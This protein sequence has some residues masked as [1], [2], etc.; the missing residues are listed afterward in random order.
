LSGGSEQA[1][2]PFHAR[3][4][5]AVVL[6]TAVLAASFVAYAPVLDNFFFPVDDTPVLLAVG[7][8]LSPT[9]HFRPLYEVWNAALL[10]LFGLRPFWWYLAGILLHAANAALVASIAMRVSGRALV[11]LASA[12]V[13]ALFYSSSD[14]VLFISANQ[15]LLSVF[16]VLLAC[17]AWI[18]CLDAR[19]ART[20]WTRYAG[21]LA[22]VALAMGFKE[23]S[24]VA[25]PLLLLVEIALRGPP[26]LGRRALARWLPLLVFV[27]AY[28]RVAFRPDLWSERADV[29]HYAFEP[30][31]A[32]ELLQNLAWLFSPR[33]VRPETWTGA[34]TLAGAALLGALAAL[35]WRFRRRAPLLWIGLLFALAAMLPVLPG[36]LAVAGSRY[37][38]P[39]GVGVAWILAG[40]VGCLLAP[41]RSAVRSP[42]RA[43]SLLAI[44]AWTGAGA[45]GIRSVESWRYDP[46]CDRHERLVRTSPVLLGEGEALLLAPPLP[47]P[48]HFAASLELYLDLPPGAVRVERHELGP[49]LFGALE[50]G[51][52]FD[53]AVR[54]VYVSSHAG[55]I[56]RIRSASEVPRE[57]WEAIAR[58]AV[59]EIDRGT[60]RLLAI[61]S[62]AP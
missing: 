33:A 55:E 26:V 59:P 25:V 41:G 1:R 21:A 11:A 39:A 20:R 44:A 54:R 50:P 47:F 46:K 36:P 10:R 27:G 23:D 57:L 32:L 35:A 9:P 14:A 40:V 31:L 60:I 34:S 62:R 5:V 7:R 51:G 48:D 53:P 19:D 16:F 43:I 6:A 22:C 61:R 17:R 4:A 3:T 45:L 52:R 37:A 24:L 29:G 30:A 49:R 56:R 42:W 15:G 13:F 8:G 2:A 18:G 12:L 58:T 28:L 38:Y